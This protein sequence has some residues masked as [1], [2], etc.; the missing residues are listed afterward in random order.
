MEQV[1]VCCGVKEEGGKFVLYPRTR[2][3]GVA[4]RIF[5]GSN[6]RWV[7]IRLM[8]RAPSRTRTQDKAFWSLFHLYC[9]SLFGRKPSSD[10]IDFMYEKL[11][12][13]LFPAR[14]DLL[15]DGTSIPKSWSMLTKEEGIEVIDR[16]M[17]LVIES[18]D[19]PDAYQ[20][21][22]RDI[23]RY[24]QSEK[25]S[26][27]ID[28]ADFSESG[29]PLTGEEWAE[30]NQ[31][32]MI[33]GIKGGDICHI[34]SRQQGMGLEW[35]VNMPWNFYRGSHDI[36]IDIQHRLGWDALFSG[37]RHLNPATGEWEW[38][39]A[40]WLKPRVERAFRLFYRGRELA[41]MNW[42]REDIIKALSCEAKASPA[43]ESGNG[44]STLAAAAL[45][46]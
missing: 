15:G 18:E 12:P 39:E 13:A 44:A 38:I 37:T 8:N 23:F 11:R 32:C 29:E 4:L 43:E 2:G 45:S 41:N 35:L 24:L 22:V 42:S 36:H 20:L 3:D 46:S 33:R 21:E 5:T 27:R 1:E 16:L 19:I 17:R 14:E 10:E 34:V 9:Q 40:P 31:L 28:P 7:N 6:G 30:R 25:G 26:L